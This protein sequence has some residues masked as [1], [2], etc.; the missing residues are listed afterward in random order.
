MHRAK[1]SA[2]YLAVGDENTIL[3]NFAKHRKNV[4]ATWELRKNDGSKA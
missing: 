4:N 2:I 3:Q 1:S